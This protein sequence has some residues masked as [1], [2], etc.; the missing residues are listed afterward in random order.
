[1]PKQKGIVIPRF[2]AGQA[3]EAKAFPDT[4][5]MRGALLFLDVC[6][7]T[8]LTE[9]ASRRG[10]YGVE[11]ITHILNSY[12]DKVNGAIYSNGGE[13][14]KFAGDAVLAYFPGEREESSRRLQGAVR[15]IENKLQSLNKGFQKTFGIKLAFHGMSSWGSFDCIIVG[16]PAYHL[17]FIFNGPALKRLFAR[18]IPARDNMV[19]MR[20]L[21]VEKPGENRL[22]IQKFPRITKKIEQKFL[23][24]VIQDT[25]NYSTFTAELRNVAILFIRIDTEAFPKRTFSKYLS[26]AFVH[27]QHCVYRYEGLVNKIDYNEKGLIVLC[28]FGIPVAHLNDI[29]RAVFAARAIVDYKLKNI[30]RIGITYANIFYGLLGAKKRYEYGVIGNSVNAA[31]RLMMEA[32]PNQILVEELIVS[33]TKLRF[34]L[35]YLKEVAVKGLAQPVKIY[36][37]D[38][39]IPVNQSS[40]ANIYAQRK[41][42]AQKEELKRIHSIF[43][44]ADSGKTLILGG[45]PGTGK[46]FFIWRLISQMKDK[47]LSLVALEEFNKPEQLYI[48]KHLWEQKTKVPLSEASPQ[49]LTN[50]CKEPRF[51]PE[52]L[53]RY[54]DTVEREVLSDEDRLILQDAMLNSALQLFC[55]L[56]A[57]YDLL[58]VD[59]LHWADRL[60]TKL[61]KEYHKARQSG[62]LL[63]S[64]RH[65]IYADEFGDAENLVLQNLSEADALQLIEYEIKNLAED[66]AKYIHKLSS[67][68]PLLIVELCAQLK[69]HLPQASRLMTLADIVGLERAGVLPHT[70]EN[71]YINRLN[72]LPADTQDLLKLAAIIG[73]AFSIDELRVLSSESIQNEV[74]KVLN[75]L[76]DMKLLNKSNISPE[77]IYIFSN[78]LM[79]EAIYNTI[80]LSEKRGLHKRIARHYEKLENGERGVELIANHYILAEYS[81]K[82]HE[83]SMLAAQKNFNSGNYEESSYFYQQALKHCQDPDAKTQIKLHLAESLFLHSEIHAAKKLLEE[84][85]NEQPG[86]ESNSKFI[87]LQ[88]K[89]RYLASDHAGLCA[90]VT[91][92]AS[93][94]CKD[95]YYLLTMIFYADSLRIMGRDKQLHDLLAELRKLLEQGLQPDNQA[96]HY[97]GMQRQN[98]YFLGKFESIEGQMALDKSQ[99]KKAR[100]HFE[101][102]LSLARQIHDNMA[103]R[104]SM[105]SLGNLFRK[106]GQLERALRYLQKAQSLCESGGDRYG[107]TKVIMDIAL[108]HRQQGDF[109]RAIQ[110]LEQSLN[111]AEVMGNKALLQNINYNIGE[112]HFQLDQ[113]AE[114]ENHLSIA[115]ELAKETSDSW[116]IS[117]AMDAM[118]DLTMAKGDLDKAEE[119]YSENLLY[120]DKLGDIEGK[121]HSLG[122]LG[123]IANARGMYDKALEYYEQNLSL[124]RKAEDVDGEGRAWYNSAIASW[125]L[126]DLAAAKH[127]L[128]TARKCFESAGS[129][130]FIDAV[131]DALK[132]LAEETKDHG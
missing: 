50:I 25:A 104:I 17:D 78:N 87:Y 117:Y 90:Y 113:L 105:Q 93:V 91:R 64:S 67:G 74:M 59:N 11:I 76:D 119:L 45:E 100:Q 14:V 82:A 116:G 31:A 30:F 8:S 4:R 81:E 51:K 10:H 132:S 69:Q 40:L 58:I 6:R 84:V 88:C 107:Y 18:E 96:L 37:I 115:L 123:N 36:L 92:S 68:N 102:A 114:A 95:D 86:Y 53:L 98:M 65:N 75:S 27:I 73:K 28:S 35:K 66:A 83:Y 110:Y 23:A 126:E 124:C 89:A 62:N 130:I 12:F 20:K 129:K 125:N 99:Y 77:I 108:V 120:Q 15:Q 112:L 39:E 34:E 47:A 33:K 24:R 122:N 9:S 41:E 60:S 79:R 106:K 22:P 54:F 52:H 127:K 48:L 55:T 57:E 19:L 42:V 3:R 43:S 118:G 85:V 32:G 2:L 38:K 29:E 49:M 7:F 101:K 13:I 71:I 63:M 128:L 131:E 5:A 94:I 80:L 97:Q 109:P 103:L 56:V 1:M 26:D 111:M 121:A 72:L 46:T 61:L 21:N 16:D 70:I 44:T